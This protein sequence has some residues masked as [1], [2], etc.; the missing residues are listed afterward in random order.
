META[1]TLRQTAGQVFRYGIA[2]GRCERNPAP[3]LHGALRPGIVKH[4]AAVL[5]PAAAGKLMRAIAEYSGQDLM[6]AALALSAL[7]F[8][9][10]G[11]IRQMAWVEIDLSAALWTIPAAKMKRSVHGKVNGRPHLVG[12]ALG[13]DRLCCLRDCRTRHRGSAMRPTPRDFSQTG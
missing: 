5:E 6:R 2:T 4:M 13:H 12:P 3:D 7:L 1:H 10:P 11:N 9:W 8:Q